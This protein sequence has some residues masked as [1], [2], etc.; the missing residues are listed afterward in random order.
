MRRWI[1]IGALFLLM[2]CSTEQERRGE[3]EV[4]AGRLS[5]E[6][7]GKGARTV[8]V[9][10]DG[11]GHHYRYL[12]DAL[13]PL[14]NQCRLLFYE[15]RYIGESQNS[16][17]PDKAT[18]GQLVDDLHRVCSSIRNQ[19]VTL[20]AHGWG[21]WLAVRYA[22]AYPEQIEG[23]VLC[24]P[25]PFLDRQRAWQEFFQA[26]ELRSRSQ[27]EEEEVSASLLH[28]VG[29]RLALPAIASAEWWRWMDP[30]T[31]ST[32]WEP[33]LAVVSAPVLVIHG[34]SDPF[35]AW[36]S[37]ALAQALPKGA[38]AELEE[39]GH[40]APLEAPEAFQEE[41]RKWLTL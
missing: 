24:S 26:A 37:V 11:P 29:A 23:L 1:G 40:Y 8:V 2:A 20:L 19:Q 14:A 28:N 35:P 39:C 16:F 13:K 34:T 6:I 25:M 3:V 33:L 5:Y 12:H 10:P 31:D 9:L 4:D 15:G 38:Y 27:G 17:R 7:I 18:W 32:E 22:A 30:F 36:A 21:A 41:V